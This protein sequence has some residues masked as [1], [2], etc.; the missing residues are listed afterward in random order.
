LDYNLTLDLDADDLE[1]EEEEH[2]GLT[3]KDVE[4]FVYEMKESDPCVVYSLAMFIDA[5]QTTSVALLL[6]NAAFMDCLIRSALK[7]QDTALVRGALV[8]LE[9]LCDSKGVADDLMEYSV[10]EHV[11]PLLSH[12]VDLIRKYAVRVLCKLCSAQ[13]W[14]MEQKLKAF[15]EHSVKECRT[16]WQGAHFATKD[17]IQTQMFDDI[18]NKLVSVQ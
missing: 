12:E 4:H 1:L 5:V 18:H 9:K 17:F 2:T 8:M 3:P 11:I 6:N 10:L 15:A 16:K 13:S 14:K 7:H